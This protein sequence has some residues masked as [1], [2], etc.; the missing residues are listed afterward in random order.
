MSSAVSAAGALWPQCPG[1]PVMKWGEGAL[2][3][4]QSGQLSDQVWSLTQFYHVGSFISVYFDIGV[5]KCFY[6]PKARS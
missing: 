4:L 2:L 3:G 5:R 1:Y 6:Q